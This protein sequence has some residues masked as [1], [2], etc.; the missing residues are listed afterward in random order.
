MKANSSG[1]IQN[2]EGAFLSNNKLRDIYFIA[3][4]EDIKSS[5]TTSQYDLS[6]YRLCS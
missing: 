2:I 5:L 1:E 6:M 3:E 4:D